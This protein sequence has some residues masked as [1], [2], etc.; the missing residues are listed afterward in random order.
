MTLGHGF[1]G[2]LFISVRFIIHTASSTIWYILLRGSIY[3]NHFFL[4]AKTVCTIAL[5]AAP[6]I[7]IICAN[8]DCTHLLT[9]SQSVGRVWQH[10][11]TN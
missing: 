6:T 9:F 3:S 4:G 1:L 7:F 8:Q 5:Y 11:I 2:H 10:I